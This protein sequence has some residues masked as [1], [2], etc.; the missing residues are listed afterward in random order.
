MNRKILKITAVFLA[1]FLLPIYVN[2][3]DIKSEIPKFGYEKLDLAVKD[4]AEETAKDGA[5]L[6][7]DVFTSDKR[8]I[9]VLVR[10]EG[11][12]GVRYK[13]TAYDK[14]C[15]RIITLKDI[16]SKSTD[17]E[18]VNADL[19]LFAYSH[20]EDGFRESD[21]YD[22][23]ITEHSIGLCVEPD[24]DGKN[25]YICIFEKSGNP[26]LCS[27]FSDKKSIFPWE[28]AV[29]FTFDDGP[30]KYTDIIL[31][32]LE[33]NNSKATFFILGEQADENA[34][35]IKRM[36]SLGCEFG[37]HGYS[38]SDMRKQSTQK[39]NEEFSKTSDLIYK[40]CGERPTVFRA[41]YGEFSKSTS[42]IK[43]PRIK[44]SVDTMDWKT[45]NRQ[46]VKDSILSCAKS[47]DIILLHDIFKTSAEGFCDAAEELKAAGYKLVTVSELLDLK[48][49]AGTKIYY[50]R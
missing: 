3:E 9:T 28:K 40:A 29:A 33:K 21:D 7:F 48:G 44:W 26:K 5:K 17:M 34:E 41:P 22:I 14:E 32:F 11:E 12:N 38:H 49:E 13:S 25:G 39:V 43:L 47:G 4:K 42:E 31:D 6:R 50:R 24:E 23:V 15:D 2:A 30:S 1:I 45:K 20:F 19:K 16:L 35:R 18:T 46:A 37:C 36:K 10:A 8:F 27:A